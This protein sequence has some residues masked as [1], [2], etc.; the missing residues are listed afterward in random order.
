M[1]VR[2]GFPK[3]LLLF[4]PLTSGAI[5]ANGRLSTNIGRASARPMLAAAERDKREARPEGRS[6][7]PGGPERGQAC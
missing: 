3:P 5:S 4:I 1:A 6:G 2:S 7:P